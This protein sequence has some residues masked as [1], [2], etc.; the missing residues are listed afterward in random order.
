MK[1]VFNSSFKKEKTI[2]CVA[3]Y[4]NSRSSILVQYADIFAG[5]NR[6]LLSKGLY[7]NSFNFSKNKILL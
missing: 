5:E 1:K 6:K 4:V 2:K 7:K 3:K